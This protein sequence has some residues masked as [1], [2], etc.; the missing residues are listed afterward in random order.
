LT[1]KKNL[2]VELIGSKILMILRVKIRQINYVFSCMM[3]FSIIIIT[4]LKVILNIN[5]I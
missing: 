2:T 1:F 5:L 3:V 4:I